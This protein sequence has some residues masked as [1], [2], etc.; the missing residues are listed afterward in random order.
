[1]KKKILCWADSPTVSTG[2]GIVNKYIMEALY[3]TGEY[4]IDVLAINCP[5]EFADAGK[6]PYQLLSTRLAGPKDVYG[7]SMFKRSILSKKYD[8]IF[9]LNDT[10]VVHP[11]SRF[12]QEMRAQYIS[13][14]EI[15]PTVVYYFPI[16]CR[17]IPQVSGFLQESDII[18]TYSDFGEQELLKVFPK[19]KDKLKKIPH[20]VDTSVYFPLSDE[21]KQKTREEIFKCS[22]STFLII[23][24]NRNSLRKDLARTIYV[25][26]KF[27]KVYS[28]SRLY[29][30][31]NP[32]DH[33]M[34]PLIDLFLACDHLGLVPHRDVVFPTNY[35]PQKPFSVELMNKLVNAADVSLSTHLG[36]GWGIGVH[37]S[38]AAGT[39]VVCPHNTTMP[40]M[41]G[42]KEERGIMYPCKDMVYIDPSG[43]RPIGYTSDI[44]QALLKVQK[45]KRKVKEKRCLAGRKWAEEHDW[46]IIGKKWIEL[47][48][49]LNQKRSTSETDKLMRGIDL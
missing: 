5:N 20:G 40:Q 35:S 11:A 44:L 29:L 18:V 28:D 43:Y 41:L 3:S 24:V 4:E 48:N 27:K 39:P 34:G 15:P 1:M 7:V 38:L 14:K 37:E 46:K 21:E 45:E 12:L 49:E 30:H 13:R 36:E 47:F 9:V 2:F 6:I 33:T 19:F 10:F 23:N 26:S 32:I 16:D 31:T 17:I 25:F 42:Y 22:K 8:Y